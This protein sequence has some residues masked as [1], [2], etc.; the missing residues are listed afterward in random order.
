MHHHRRDVVA[1]CHP[2]SAIGRGPTHVLGVQLAVR[3]RRTV[4]ALD[5]DPGRGGDGTPGDEVGQDL[6]LLEHGRVPL[7]A[8]GYSPAT[9]ITTRPRTEPARICSARA[10][11]GPTA[12]WW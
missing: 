12:R 7:D 2:G 11:R 8:A 5:G 4:D 1:D 9:S 10:A 3:H 6:I